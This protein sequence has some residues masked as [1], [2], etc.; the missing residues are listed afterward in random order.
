MQNKN[1]IISFIVP[2]F[3]EKE[4][5]EKTILK[6][7]NFSEK[8]GI[9]Y[10]ILLVDDRSKDGTIEII[11]NMQKRNKKIRLMVRPKN[12]GFGFS[13]IDGSKDALGEIVV[14][15]MGD[16]SD[17]LETVLLMIEKINS[18]EDMVIGSRN[19][20]GGSRGD[21]NKLKAIGSNV[22]SRLA[23]LLFGLPVYDITNAFR[24]FRKKLIF[25][26]KLENNNFAISPE[27]AIKAHVHGFKIAEVP[28]TYNERKV[29]QAKT[30]LFKMGLFYYKM[31]F[32]YYFNQKDL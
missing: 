12:P 18:G 10:D 31:L 14:W 27:F 29:G 30:K 17:N 15:I 13:L 8:N 19:M 24:A 4:N 25:K 1:Q 3:N 32:R 22:F 6:L 9:N 11:R 21:Q 26:I 20:R 16:A 23:R 2:C 5:I 7:V 28:T